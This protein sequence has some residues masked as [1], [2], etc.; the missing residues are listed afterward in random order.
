MAKTRKVTVT[1][2]EDIAAT[3]EQWRDAGRISSV[4]E[5]V[6]AQVQAGMQRAAM[7]RSIE[8]V[9]GGAAGPARPPLAAI[10]RSR[11]LLGLPELTPE[12]AE[13]VSAEAWATEPGAAP[14]A[15]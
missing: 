5:Y 10:N 12:Q 1:V 2:P 15:A 9:Y 11:R 3:L 6:T 13:A 14:G 8:T 7:L 4:S